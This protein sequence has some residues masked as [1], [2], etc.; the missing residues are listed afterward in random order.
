ME[1]NK[2]SISIK[3]REGHEVIL[4]VNNAKINEALE[5]MD[6][7]LRFKHNIDLKREIENAR[8]ITR[9]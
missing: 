4:D 9:I 2:L 7:E 3:I 5:S 6:T 8:R 1:D